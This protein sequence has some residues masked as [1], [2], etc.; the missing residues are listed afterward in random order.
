MRS[1][2]GLRGKLFKF[3]L[4]GG[5]NTGVMY[6]LYIGLVWLGVHYNIAL[7]IDYAVGIV[8]AYFMNRY[9]T[10]ASHGRPRRSFQK[11]C[12]TY[13]MVYVINM[14]LLNAIVRLGLLGPV[15]GQLAALSVATGVSFLLQN[16]WVFHSGETK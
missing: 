2:E 6:L 11:Y 9:W 7:I 8:A 16:F 3:I 10:F 14:V 4:V 5:L 13:G 15:L 12:A 1:A